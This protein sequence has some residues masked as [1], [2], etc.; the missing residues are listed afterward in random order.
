MSNF[1]KITFP[2]IDFQSEV[3]IAVEQIAFEPDLMEEEFLNKSRGGTKR[4]SDM[5]F[6]YYCIRQAERGRRVDHSTHYYINE[7]IEV[8]YHKN[9]PESTHQDVQYAINTHTGDVAFLDYSDSE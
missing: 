9:M 4:I 7:H 6:G 3:R 2:D 8:T 1:V 5:V